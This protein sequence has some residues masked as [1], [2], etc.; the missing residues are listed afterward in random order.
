MDPQP[1]PRLRPIRR[2]VLSDP[3]VNAYLLATGYFYTATT[4]WQRQL[5][6]YE[7]PPLGVTV[8]LEHGRDYDGFVS[9]LRKRSVCYVILRLREV[10]VVSWVGAISGHWPADYASPRH[11]YSPRLVEWV[12]GNPST[13]QQ[14]Y[15]HAGNVV[16]R[17]R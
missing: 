5:D 13:F 1:D 17:L 11:Y 7:S 8:G 12:S 10:P 9:L 6:G 14:V 3:Y 15:E 2:Y 4:R 16:Y